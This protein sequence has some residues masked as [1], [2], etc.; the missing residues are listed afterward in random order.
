MLKF[1]RHKFKEPKHNQKTNSI[2]SNKTKTDRTQQR[3]KR[4]QIGAICRSYSVNCDK[5]TTLALNSDKDLQMHTQTRPL[6]S[7][8]ERL[9]LMNEE[10]G[11]Q[12]I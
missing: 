8:R 3:R 6:Y 5:C 1:R 7:E 11:R 4:S 12:K 10:N 2:N 9:L